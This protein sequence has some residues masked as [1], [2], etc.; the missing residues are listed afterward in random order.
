MTDQR[1]PFDG[2]LRELAGDIWRD[3]LHLSDESK[4][5][6]IADTL[7][8]VLR[9]L[10]QAADH[11]AQHCEYAPRVCC[12]EMADRLRAELEKFKEGQ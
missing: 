9:P 11:M 3:S 12:Q 1:T 4:Q 7:R 6:A 8:D 2:K 10:L 5:E